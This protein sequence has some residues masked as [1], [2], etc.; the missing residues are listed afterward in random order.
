MKR[1]CNVDPVNFTLTV[2]ATR[3]SE[4]SAVQPIYT[5]CHYAE[6]GSAGKPI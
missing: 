5:R 2:E 4:T 6:T 3:I 1:K